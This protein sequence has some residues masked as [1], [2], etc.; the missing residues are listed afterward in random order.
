MKLKCILDGEWFMRGLEMIRVEIAIYQLGLSGVTCSAQGTVRNLYRRQLKDTD[1]RYGYLN[2]LNKAAGKQVV[3]VNQDTRL[4]NTVLDL[5]GQL[6]RSKDFWQI[7]TPNIIAGSSEGGAD[8]FKFEY[9]KQPACLAQSHQLH[10]QMAICGDFKRA[11]VQRGCG[12]SHFI[13]SIKDGDMKKVHNTDSQ[14]RPGLKFRMLDDILQSAD[15]EYTPSVFAERKIRPR[16]SYVAEK[17]QQDCPSNETDVEEMTLSQLMKKCKSKIRKASEPVLLT[18]KEE[19]DDIDLS[20]PLFKFRKVSKCSPSKKIPASKNSTDVNDLVIVK[21]KVEALQE[22]YFDCSADPF[23][24]NVSSMFVASEDEVNNKGSGSVTNEGEIAGVSEVS[25]DNLEN[26]ELI[27]E[28]NMP[29]DLLALSV[30]ELDEA[31]Y[32]DQPLSIVSSP[33]DDPSFEDLNCF[34]SQLYLQQTPEEVSDVSDSQGSDLAI[35]D[36]HFYTDI[37]DEGSPRNQEFGSSEP[38]RPF[39]EQSSFV[40]ETVDSEMDFS[41]HNHQTDVTIEAAEIRNSDCIETRQP[42][43]LPSTRKAISPNSQEKLC[44]SMKSTELPDDMDL[45]KC[46]EKLY[47]G[48]PAENT[49]SSKSDVSDNKPSVHLQRATPIVQNR[50]YISPRQLLQR[51]KICKKG[52]PPISVAPKSC[53]DGPRQCRSLPRLST[54]CTSIQGCSQNAIAFSQRQMQDIESLAS[55]LITELNSM[56]VIAEEKMLY[57]AYRSPSA[58]NE[59]D[60]VKSAIK[61]ATKTEET[62]KKWLSM[63]SRDCNRFCKIMKLNEDKNTFASA[64]TAPESTTVEKPVQR[65]RKKISFA[66]EAGGTLCDIKVFH[67]EQDSSELNEKPTNITIL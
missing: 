20:E 42:E 37:S 63:M 28:V 13:W 55:K 14:G 6:L 61:S 19:V 5:F 8:V 39:L 34:Q 31:E 53:L 1:V 21:V 30:S 64:D 48:E 52:S 54:G 45:F 24:C 58:K 23:D 47:F 60:E 56:R 33:E 26:T 15:G 3:R 2:I 67:I 65:E 40:P 18:S 7:I 29:N 59:A 41:D 9:K 44:Q 43:R 36:G 27:D 25:L 57:E 62:A 50:V 16:S 46:K 12:N 10:K 51:P 11:F 35:D 22:E 49:F 17:D 4:N 32:V 66:D 38:S